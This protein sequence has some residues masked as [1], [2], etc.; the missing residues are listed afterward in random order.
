M[1]DFGLV[2]FEVVVGVEKS[3]KKKTYFGT[4]LFYF[5]HNLPQFKTALVISLS[6]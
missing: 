5:S 4:I 3:K 6:L 2:R 1:K